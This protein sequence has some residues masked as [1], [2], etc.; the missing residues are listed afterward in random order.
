MSEKLY[1]GLWLTDF[2]GT[3][4]PDEPSDPV[5]AGDLEALRELG[6]R[7]WFRAVVTGRS[8]FSFVTTW[9]PD[10]E[11]DG[12]IFSS[13]VGLC[14]WEAQGPGP[15]RLARTFT[16]AEAETALKAAQTLGFGFFAYLA[17]PDSH[18]FYYLAP[19]VPPAGFLKR[20]KMYAPQS[21]PFTENYWTNPPT[22]RPPLSQLLIMVPI[23]VANQI[24]TEFS[25]LAPGLSYLRSSSPFGDGCQWIEIFPPN[26][27]KGQAAAI[28]AER[29]GLS[30]SQAV[31]LGNDYNDRDLLSWA[32]RA[33]VTRD[34]PTELLGLY[35]TIDP[36]GFGGLAQA[37]ALVEAETK[38]S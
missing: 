28:L 22:L 15:L 6:R 18:H 2:D 3:I 17:P 34:A 36:A 11:L 13:G 26:V 25:R 9:T 8:L 27:S 14:L 21:R 19:P 29:L 23:T 38:V 1:Q 24:E 16:P 35:R 37:T 30:S 5:A 10:L 32:G 7:G 12:L 4:K 20:L 31:A 33:F